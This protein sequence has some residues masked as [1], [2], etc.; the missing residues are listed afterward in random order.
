M[1]STHF[2]IIDLVSRFWTYM[3]F[4][5][6]SATEKATKVRQ[7][8]GDVYPKSQASILS[9]AVSTSASLAQ[10][11]GVNTE[12]LKCMQHLKH[13]L[14]YVFGAGSFPVILRNVYGEVE[15][16]STSAVL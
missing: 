2:S 9:Q 12:N 1:D 4:M 10:G 15:S 13:D 5:A 3:T 14:I 11:L 6:S 16:F 8:C 7:V